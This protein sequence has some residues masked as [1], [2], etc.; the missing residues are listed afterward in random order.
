MLNY[1]PVTKKSGQSFAVGRGAVAIRLALSNLSIKDGYVLVPANICYAAVLPVIYSGFSP[2]FCDV[3]PVSGNVTLNSVKCACN[4]DVIAA[5][6][7]HMYGNPV[8]EF[9]LIYDYLHSRNV[10]VIEDCAS[11]MTNKGNNYIPGTIGDY[12]VYSTGYSKTID[13]GFGGLLFSE[14]NDLNCLESVENNL[15]EFDKSYELEWSSFSAVYRILRNKGQ[16]TSIAKS[17]FQNLPSSFS[18]SYNFRVS[19]EQKTK[20]IESID[21]LDAVIEERRRKYK[22]YLSSLEISEEKVYSF[23]ADSVP[24]RFNML[25]GEEREEFIKYCLD[26]KLPVSDWYPLV[27]PIFGDNKCYPNAEWHEKHIVNFPILISDEKIIEI[28]NIINQYYRG[29]E[30]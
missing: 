30:S 12:V 15:N 19:E 26:N 8:N 23:S 20:I 2:L 24:W 9:L 1:N 18:D 4:N 6:I 21:T 25:L 29:V 7:P 10:T 14:R 11:L 3:D 28:C 5:I 27:T 13:I 17:V 22:L 16:H